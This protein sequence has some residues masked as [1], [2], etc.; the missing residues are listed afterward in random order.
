MRGRICALSAA[1]CCAAALVAVGGAPARAGVTGPTATPK[2]PVA[3]GTGGGAATMSPYATAAAVK[4]LRQGGNAVDAAVAAATTLGVTEPFV[5]GPGGGG[6]FVYYRARDHKVFTIEGREKAPAG[7]QPD[8][9]L[10]ASGKQLPFE[11]A[12]ESGVSVGVPGQVAT[13]GVAL[14]RFGT[15]SLATVLKPAEDVAAKGFPLD[16]PLVNAIQTNQAKLARFPA[17]AKL[18]LPGGKVPSVGDRLRNPDLARTYRQ[19]GR[20]GYRWFYTGPIASQLSAATRNV[21]VSPGSAQ[22]AGG[23]MTATD[24]ANYRAVLRDPVSWT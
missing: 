21:A 2:Q 4:I 3:Y 19:L 1:V 18:F 14:R 11:Q 13:W 8:M 9:F 6:Y 10:D 20:H 23:T 12:V 7:A 17:S 22:V 16:V 24:L 15:R 5:A